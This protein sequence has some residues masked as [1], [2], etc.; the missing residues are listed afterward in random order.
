MNDEPLEIPIW[1]V[2][3]LTILGLVTLVGFAVTPYIHGQPLLLTP[4][5]RAAKEYLDNYQTRLTQSEKELSILIG[6]LTPTSAGASGMFAIA[7]KVRTSQANLNAIAREVERTRVPAELT[8]LDQA[9]RSALAAELDLADR[10]LAF[11]GRGDE[12][13]RASALT[14]AEDVK[15]KLS[16]A[17]N[18][19]A[20]SLR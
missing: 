9:L 2:A 15:L 17:R 6:V 19:Y 10:A 5:N 8:Q 16:A 11:A 18:A 3:L 12:E 1:L 13:T 4:E 14:A 7:P 20:D